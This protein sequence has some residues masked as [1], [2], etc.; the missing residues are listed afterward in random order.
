MPAWDD[1]QYL[2]FADERTRPAR[3][4]LSRVP[5]EAAR[6]IVDLG[7][8]PGNST[9][10]L[11]NRWPGAR[12]VGVDDS[13]QMLRRARV[14]WPALEWVES[15]VRTFRADTPPDL[16]F[17]NAVFHW[18]PDHDTLI[19]F[20]VDQLAPKGVLAVQMPLVLDEPSH[21]AMRDVAAS[22]P[23]RFD[24][25]QPALPIGTAADY[26]D[27]LAP[28]ARHV[29]V[30]QT[31]YEH[32]MPDIAAI[33]EWVKGTSLRPYL[34]ILPEAERPLFLERYAQAL[35]G[36]YP[37]RSDGRRLFSFPRLFFVAV[38]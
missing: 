4:L 33:V 29:D 17:A 18:V 14:D 27:L 31:R 3:E 15:D 19:P 6:V 10:L 24:A 7:C 1:T 11:H 35:E 12:I 23:G 9:A 32:V 22:M 2:K 37:Q 8:G 34:E 36:V 20:L 16:I 25:V 26:Y 13:P 28:Q 5:L 38:R 21:R 30:W